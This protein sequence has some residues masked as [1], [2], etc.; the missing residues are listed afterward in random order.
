LKAAYI[1]F[2]N[3]ISQKPVLHGNKIGIKETD[4]KI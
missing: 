4:P 1:A 2:T 3:G